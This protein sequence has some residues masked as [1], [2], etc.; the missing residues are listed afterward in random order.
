MKRRELLKSALAVAA[1]GCA[2]DRLSTGTSLSTPLPAGALIG[3]D[4]GLSRIDAP[5]SSFLRRETQDRGAVIP[6]HQQQLLAGSL[7]TLMVAGALHDLPRGAH[8]HPEVRTRISS[9]IPE[10]ARSL[11][12]MTRHMEE[13]APAERVLL[14]RHLRADPELPLRAAEHL[15][16]LAASAGLGPTSRWK[17]RD[18]ATRTAWRL[19]H[20]PVSMLLDDTTSRVHKAEGRTGA[21]SADAR[22]SLAQVMAGGEDWSEEDEYE[23]EQPYDEYEEDQAGVEQTGPIEPRPWGGRGLAIAGGVGG[24]LGLIGGYAALV[25][26]YLNSIGSDPQAGPITL[27]IIS[28]VTFVAGV[29]VMISGLVMKSRQDRLWLERNPGA[30]KQRR[31][32]RR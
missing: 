4:R 32:R 26:A 10:G 11:Y 14:Q 20:Q 7:R 2:A 21:F 23:D 1:S 15:D 24:I 25:W 3:L 28:G 13:L 5:F 16:A 27:G 22:L 17:L 8:A 12:G 30:R 19:G 9:I 6:P 18:L 31:R 29:V